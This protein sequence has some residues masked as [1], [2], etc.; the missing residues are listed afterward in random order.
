MTNAL[1]NINEL[2]TDDQI[3]VYV[4]NML[5]GELEPEQ[6]LK[7]AFGFIPTR[8]QIRE[9]ESSE[10]YQTRMNSIITTL[11][12]RL[13][14]NSV[15]LADAALSEAAVIL[16][17]TRKQ[18]DNLLNN[19]EIDLKNYIQLCHLQINVFKVIKDELQKAAKTMNEEVD[20]DEREWFEIRNGS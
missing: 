13:M 8:E 19:D 9:I 7:K 4:S 17:Q 10:I 5:G 18:I 16:K 15:M 1:A 2:I 11:Q 6:C 12:S 14:S 3:D 20:E